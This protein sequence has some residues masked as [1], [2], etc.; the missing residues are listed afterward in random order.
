MPATAEGEG[1]G[2]ADGIESPAPPLAAAAGATALALAGESSA[3]D[4]PPA[5]TL[6]GV[7]FCCCVAAWRGMGPSKPAEL[8]R[9]ERHLL[10]CAAV[11]GDPAL[12]TGET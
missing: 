3:A 6:G 1:C 7:A 9:T 2:A 5:K 10:P 11:V 12:A 4:S 8:A